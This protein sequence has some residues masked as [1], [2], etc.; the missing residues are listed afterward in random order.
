MSKKDKYTIK[1]N[2]VTD[3]KGNEYSLSMYARIKEDDDYSELQKEM[4]L[5][6]FNLSKNNDKFGKAARKFL[7]SLHS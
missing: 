4:L 6:L 5:S 7:I 2:S 1:V 3:E